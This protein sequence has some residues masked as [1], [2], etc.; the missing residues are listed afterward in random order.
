ML[1]CY[2]KSLYLYVRSQKVRGRNTGSSVILILTG[3]NFWRY[4][5]YKITYKQ[6]KQGLI[7]WDQVVSPVCD[8]CTDDVGRIDQDDPWVDGRPL[9]ISTSL[10]RM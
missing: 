7:P 3:H 9:D 5:Q 6:A 10:H 1:N 2:W 8:W 4:H